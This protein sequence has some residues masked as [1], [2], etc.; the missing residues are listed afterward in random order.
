MFGSP[1]A[2]KIGQIGLLFLLEGL[3]FGLEV[4]TGEAISLQSL[5]VIP[6]IVSGLFLGRVGIILFSVISA[7]LRVEAYRRTQV[8][9]P[10]FDY[11]TSLVFTLFSYLL[12]G[13]TVIFGMTYQKR[14][15]ANYQSAVGRR[16]ANIQPAARPPRDDA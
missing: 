9:E 2:R 3:I 12:V 13:A 6:I 14:Y 10:E 7:I 8:H 16:I 5:F 15:E 4:W 11:V 1:T